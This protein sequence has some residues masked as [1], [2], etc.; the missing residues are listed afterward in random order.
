MPWLVHCTATALSPTLLLCN[1]PIVPPLMQVT[2]W[3]LRHEWLE[4][5]YR[6]HCT[7]RRIDAVL[8]DA[9]NTVRPL[10]PGLFSLRRA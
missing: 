9:I 2:F 1:A 5:L 8:L 3:D 10:L 7:A 4:L 6:H